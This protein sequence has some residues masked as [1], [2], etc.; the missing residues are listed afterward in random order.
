MHFPH[1]LLK[2]RN[3]KKKKDIFFIGMSIY[4]F[5]QIEVYQYEC[6]TTHDLGGERVRNRDI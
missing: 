6:V 1:R 3:K 5:I 4:R 2:N